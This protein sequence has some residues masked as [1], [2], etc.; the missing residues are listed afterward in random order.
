[1]DTHDARR[2]GN[3]RADD[4]E[5][6]VENIGAANQ[7]GRPADRGA[8][9]VDVISRD[10]ARRR[11]LKRYF[12][13]EPC[14]R[15]HVAERQV[16]NGACLRCKVEIEMACRDRDPERYK[17]KHKAWVDKRFG[18]DESFRL[19]TRI[20]KLKYAHFQKERKQVKRAAKMLTDLTGVPHQIVEIVDAGGRKTWQPRPV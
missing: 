9:S 14:K 8:D 13:G 16:A 10:E 15:G 12:T 3:N 4:P 17:A 20:R 11:G 5:R 19:K 18:E 1:M 6:I 7:P 2:R